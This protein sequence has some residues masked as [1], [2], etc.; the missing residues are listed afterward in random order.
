MAARIGKAKAARSATDS[1]GQ[2]DLVCV[3]SNVANTQNMEQVMASAG[4]TSTESPESLVAQETVTTQQDVPE[5]DR[6]HEDGRAGSAINDAAAG[7]LL[8]PSERVGTVE[9]NDDTEHISQAVVGE[10]SV[11]EQRKAQPQI[12]PEKEDRSCRT[13]QQSLTENTGKCRSSHREGG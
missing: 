5:P 10:Q 9:L 4:T 3:P 8:A 2:R 11:S 13:T 7:V 6:S 12:E 1:P